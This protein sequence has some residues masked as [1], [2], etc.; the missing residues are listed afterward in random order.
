M[1]RLTLFGAVAP[2]VWGTTYVVTT[3]LLPPGHPMTASVLRAL[4]A[5]L[6]LI[7][8]TRTWPRQWGRLLVLTA[9]TEIPQ[10]CSSNLPT[11]GRSAA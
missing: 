1:L 8:L 3:E 9:L 7:A 5:G 4:P 11:L 2:M 10:F 6:L